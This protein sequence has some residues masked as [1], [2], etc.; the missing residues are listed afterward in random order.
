MATSLGGQMPWLPTRTS[1]APKRST[2]ALTS[3]SAVAGAGEIGL[4]RMAAI[5]AAV[6]DELLGF[7]CRVQV[8]EDHVRA[9]AN[10][11]TDGGCP[12]S[13]RASGDEGDFTS[14]ESVTSDVMGRKN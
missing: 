14:R 13:A 3:A 6:R 12:D 8:V 4:D 1:S 10:K 2:A 11:E 7:G 5:G 9:G